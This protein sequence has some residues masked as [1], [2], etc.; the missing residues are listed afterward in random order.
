VKTGLP[1]TGTKDQRIANLERQVAILADALLFAMTHIKLQRQSPIVG[2]EP[3][4]INMAEL[5]RQAVEAKQAQ[6]QTPSTEQP[7]NQVII[8]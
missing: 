7:A 4:V 5:Y 2:A 8:N 3:T 6:E 1:R